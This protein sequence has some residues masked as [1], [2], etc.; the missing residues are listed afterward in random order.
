[1][2]G[3]ALAAAR[4]I[5]RGDAE[6]RAGTE[7]LFDDGVNGGSFLL[8]GTTVGLVGC[9]SLGRALLPLL[10][11]FG[12]R[13][14]AH[15]PWLDDATLRAL[16]VEPTGLVELFAGARV[17]FILARPRPRT[18]AQSD[19]SASRRWLQARSWCWSRGRQS[20]TGPRFS[21]PRPRA[22]SG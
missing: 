21:M 1:A 18:W 14:L 12:C 22:G 10:R 7:T 5:P 13:L 16:G 8:A 20:S 15:D 3:M 2:L 11:P 6:I 17:V 9:G 4:D 19:A